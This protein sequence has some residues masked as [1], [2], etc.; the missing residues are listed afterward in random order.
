MGI[1]DGS[2]YGG[3]GH[4]I[5][6]RVV[7]DLKRGDRVYLAVRRGKLIVKRYDPAGDVPCARCGALRRYWRITKCHVWGQIY[8]RHKAV[9]NNFC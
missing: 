1:D 5:R 7:E 9:E 8:P 2:I 6:Y 3:G 4:P